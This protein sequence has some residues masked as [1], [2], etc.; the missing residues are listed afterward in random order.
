M[1]MYVPQG[2]M[3]SA[4]LA[5]PV[6]IHSSHRSHQLVG[7]GRLLY[8]ICYVH[9]QVQPF[10][11]HRVQQVHVAYVP[12]VFGW[13]VGWTDISEDRGVVEAAVRLCLTS[14]AGRESLQERCDWKAMRCI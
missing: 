13:M 7:D 5:R 9:V 10:K 14:Y 6:M 12:R 1:I 2:A 11:P 4:L 3:F 8:A